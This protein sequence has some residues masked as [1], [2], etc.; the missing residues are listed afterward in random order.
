MDTHD[1]KQ[2]P[3]ENLRTIWFEGEMLPKW[4]QWLDAAA[5][6]CPV[7]EETCGWF[8]RFT[9]N[10]GTD[11]AR[12]VMAEAKILERALRE[13]QQTILH[14]MRRTHDDQQAERIFGAWLYA[15]ETM[16][17]VAASRK[18]CHWRLDG[19]EKIGEDDGNGDITLRRV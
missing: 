14:R 9:N 15:L 5:R 12:T 3:D 16:V 8:S 4:A 1:L 19:A 17:Q 18:T 13:N 7:S 6:L 11:D 10:P 2:S